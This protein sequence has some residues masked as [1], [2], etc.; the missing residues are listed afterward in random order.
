MATIQVSNLC[1]TGFEL[2]QG[3]ESFLNDLSEQEVADISG[4]WYVHLLRS[5]ICFGNGD[6]WS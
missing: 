1:P 4:G 2:F 5:S 3:S 6:Y